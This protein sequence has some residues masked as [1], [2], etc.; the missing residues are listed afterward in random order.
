MISNSRLKLE[1]TSFFLKKMKDNID[2]DPDFDYYLNAFISS[3]RSIKWIINKEYS[4]DAGWENWNNDLSLKNEEKSFLKLI[5][6]LRNISI[7]EKPLMTNKEYIIPVPE[8]IDLKEGTPYSVVAVAVP[9]D[10]K[11][12]EKS[13]NTLKQELESY[14]ISFYS[15]IEILR[16]LGDSDWDILCLCQNYYQW[17]DNIV[18]ECETRFKRI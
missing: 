15:K 4:K 5:T 6:K 16:T 10:Q 14:S 11:I 13:E 1:E 2:I 7:K 3:A 12:N 18:S 8:E 17:L 9:K